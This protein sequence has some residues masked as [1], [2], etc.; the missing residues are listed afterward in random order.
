MLLLHI[1]ARLHTA[2]TTT[3][4]LI[5]WHWG[6]FLLHPHTVLIPLSI[7][8][9]MQRYTIFFIAV[10]AVYVQVSWNSPMLAEA[11]SKRDTY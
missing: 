8:D 1:N 4:L 6:H 5:T 7:T 3:A 2:H 10:N 11:A 9:K